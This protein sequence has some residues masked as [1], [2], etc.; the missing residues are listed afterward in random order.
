MARIPYAVVEQVLTTRNGLKG[1]MVGGLLGL[2]RGV[3][4]ATSGGL[5]LVGR[6][7]TVKPFPQGDLVKG[8]IVTAMALGNDFAVWLATNDGIGWSASVR[9]L[10]RGEHR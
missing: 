5:S 9:T 1:D 7:G 2:P 10:S 6:D 3:L 4:A 8:S